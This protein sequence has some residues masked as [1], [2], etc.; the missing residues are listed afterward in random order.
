MRVVIELKKGEQPDVILSSLY[1]QTNLQTSFSANMVC[2][3][4][5]EPCTINIPRAL[6]EFIKHRREVITRRTLYLLNKTYTKGH[7]LE[8][9]SVAL[10]NIDEM[11]ELI[12]SSKSTEEAR[13]KIINK[14]WS[15]S[16][17]SWNLSKLMNEC[18]QFISI[19][20]SVGLINKA[21][22]ISQIKLKLF[23]I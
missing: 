4:D 11:I 10:K 15:T 19:D 21:Y 23:L 6:S 3:V 12:K 16:N 2:L 8:G 18:S 7:L 14:S 1:K 9:L 20:D 22:K 17:M 5:G 13:D